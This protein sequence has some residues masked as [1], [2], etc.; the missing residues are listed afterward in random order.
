MTAHTLRRSPRG[1]AQEV[2]MVETPDTKIRSFARAIAETF[3]GTVKKEEGVWDNV[4]VCHYDVKGFHR[5]RPILFQVF[6]G[7]CIAEAA[8]A[9]NPA[10]DVALNCPQKG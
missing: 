4:T 1:I 10:E 3:A 6:D 7:G 8:T 2:D 5:D 9:R